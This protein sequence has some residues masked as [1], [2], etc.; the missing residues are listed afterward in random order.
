[1]KFTDGFWHTRPGVDA[2]YAREV[3]DVEAGDG[4]LVV[5]APTKVINGRGDTLNTAALQVTCPPRHPK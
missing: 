2:L 3:F 5:T 1:M 4:R